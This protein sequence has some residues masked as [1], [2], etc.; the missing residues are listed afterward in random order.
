MRGM[1]LN[2]ET[3]L[4]SVGELAEL[5][6]GT[7]RPI[8]ATSSTLTLPAVQSFKA[9]REAIANSENAGVDIDFEP[10]DELDSEEG[11][12]AESE[13][14]AALRQLEREKRKKLKRIIILASIATILV[15]FAVLI[16]I[17]IF[18]PDAFKGKPKPPP[19]AVTTTSSEQTET[20]AKVSDTLP[21]VGEMQVTNFVGAKIDENLM[22]SWENTYKFLDF[23]FRGEYS[24]EHERDTVFE[25]SIKHGDI[26][27]EGTKIVIKYSLGTE[28]V[29]MPD[30]TGMKVDEFRNQL[31]SM[32]VRPENIDI[33]EAESPMFTQEG[34]VD[35][36]S[37]EPGKKVRLTSYPGDET[38]MADKIIIFKAIPLETKPPKSTPKPTPTTPKPTPTTPR[39]TT[40]KPP[41]APPTPPPTI[42]PTEPPDNT[43][44]PPPA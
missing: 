43:V 29:D 25:Q 26:V 8:S 28:F 38:R 3:R 20:T 27:T 41:T 12:G 11:G 34:L 19:P 17:A 7:R 40:P 44:E 18:N 32:G 5:L 15:V 37:I 13:T 16:M 2:T 4:K 1:E 39:P 21:P 24:E 23:D 36:C 31:I 22:K 35:G 30:Y 6:W 14:L 33:Q 9:Q 10:D 42:P